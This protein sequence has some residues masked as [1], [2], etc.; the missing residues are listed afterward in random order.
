MAHMRQLEKDS[1]FN[2]YDHSGPKLAGWRQEREAARM[3]NQ[4]PASVKPRAAIRFLRT[5]WHSLGEIFG[6]R[7]IAE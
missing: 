6:N 7:F 3:A 1:G 2:G 4:D 5:T